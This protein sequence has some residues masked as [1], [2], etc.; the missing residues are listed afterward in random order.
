M[1]VS[2]LKDASLHQAGSTPGIFTPGSARSN[3]ARDTGERE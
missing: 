1:I 2:S 3:R